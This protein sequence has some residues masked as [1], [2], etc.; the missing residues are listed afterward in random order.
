MA[1]GD[2]DYEGKKL[3]KSIEKKL[4]KIIPLLKPKPNVPLAQEDWLELVSSVHFL[5]EVQ[6][7]SLK[8]SFATL[9]TEKQHLAKYSEEAESALRKFSLL[10]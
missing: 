3:E 10:S 1:S 2:Q 4:K 9:K 5:R 6:G 8:D 7:L